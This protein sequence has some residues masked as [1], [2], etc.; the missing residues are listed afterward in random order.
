M[1]II[2][3]RYISNGEKNLFVKITGEGETTIIIE[4]GWGVAS[5]EWS[6]IQHEISSLTKVLSYDRAGYAESPRGNLPRTGGDIAD[7]LFNTLQN[8][9]INPPVIL[10]GQAAGAMYARRFAKMFPAAVKGLVL[11]DAISE[12]ILEIEKQ[13]PE[14]YRE[15]SSLKKRM[16]G[17]ENL[18]NIEENDFEK[19]LAPLVNNLY[20]GLPEPVQEQLRTYQTERK[21]YQTILDEYDGLLGTI[22]EFGIPGN[23]P[24]MPVKVISHDPIEMVQ[25]ASYIGVSEEEARLVEEIWFAEQK[26]LVELYPNG[27]LIIAKGAGVN[28]HL[29]H[30]NVIIEAVKQLL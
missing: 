18:M 7:E 19:Q 2:D 4:P 12:N 23:T 5:S 10:I 29:T 6:M 24:D 9:G 1:D 11:V 26:R 14:P 30:S 13:Y 25:I 15:N 27:E 3:G 28:L 21:F 8:A 22:E 16:M 17:I 20:P